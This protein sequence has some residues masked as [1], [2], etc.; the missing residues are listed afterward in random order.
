VRFWPIPNRCQTTIEEK[1]R[2]QKERLLFQLLD[3][4]KKTLAHNTSLKIMPFKYLAVRIAASITSARTIFA[5]YLYIFEFVP[6]TFLLEV[7]LVVTF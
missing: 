6:V 1:K 2:R 4:P 7:V 3:R 5:I